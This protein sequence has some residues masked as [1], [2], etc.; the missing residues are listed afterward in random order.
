MPGSEL[1]GREGGLDPAF[2]AGVA[3]QVGGVDPQAVQRVGS[4]AGHRSWSKNPFVGSSSA[5][6]WR[7]R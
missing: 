3:Q 5:S 7:G 4:H 6:V 1:V 2:G